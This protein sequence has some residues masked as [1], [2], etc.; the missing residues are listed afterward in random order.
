MRQAI[1]Q[2]KVTQGVRCV[3]ERLAAHRRHNQVAAGQQHFA[4]RGQQ[5]RVLQEATLAR[6]KDQVKAR[7]RGSACVAPRQKLL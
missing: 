6:Q 4:Q 7:T 2:L 3:G 5:R 1:H